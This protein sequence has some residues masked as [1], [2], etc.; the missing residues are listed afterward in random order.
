MATPNTSIVKRASRLMLIIICISYLKLHCH[1]IFVFFR[2]FIFLS[3]KILDC[4]DAH[5]KLSLKLA[6]H[7]S[8]QMNK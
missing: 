6:K 3:V 2:M 5:S 4:P 8:T 7:T 1:C